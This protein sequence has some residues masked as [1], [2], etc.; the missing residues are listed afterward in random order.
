MITPYASESPSDSSQPIASSSRHTLAPAPIITSTP[1]LSRRL[2]RS[3]RRQLRKSALFFVVSSL[4]LPLFASANPLPPLLTVDSDFRHRSR[5]PSSPGLAN[6]HHIMSA[7]RQLA[8][9]FLARRSNGTDGPTLSIATY[10]PILQAYHMP[11]GYVV[12]N[13]QFNPGFIVLS[14]VI[15]FVGSLCTLELLIRRTTNS[16]WRNQ[17]LL[18]SAGFCFGAVSTFAMHFVFNN[19][20]SLHHPMMDQR[21]YP[22]LYLSYDP[23]FTILSLVVSCLAMTMAFFVMGTRLKDWLILPGQRRKDQMKRRGSPTKVEADDYGKWKKSH[24]KIVRRGTMGVGALFSQA[25]QAAKWSL[26]DGDQPRRTSLRDKLSGIGKDATWNEEAQ[27]IYSPRTETCDD[28]IGD[29]EALKE[30]DFRFGKDAVRME[31]ERRAGASTPTSTITS[32]PPSILHPPGSSG[33]LATPLPVIYASSSRRGSTVSNPVETPGDVFVPGFHFP[34]KA[35]PDYDAMPSLY[36]GGSGQL[37]TAFPMRDMS[38]TAGPEGLFAYQSDRRRASLPSNMLVTHRD[39]PSYS[40]PSSTL[41]RIQSLPEGD[42]EPATV[43][44]QHSK[45][46]SYD[47]K[48]APEVT[49]RSIIARL[50]SYS[51]RTDQQSERTKKVRLVSRTTRWTRIGMFL[52]L[53]VVTPVEVLKILI[54][55]TIAGCGVAGMH[56]IGQASITGLP[57]IAY[58]PSYVVG[59]IIIACGA[60]MIA[61]YIMFIMLRPKLKH[62]WFSKICVALILAVAVT[63]MHFCGM[64]G[65]VYA[66]PVGR[67]ISRHSKLTGT[68]VVITGIVAAL[69]FSACI[70]CAI[71]FLL[72]S[73][74]QRRERA[75]RRRV[76]VAAILLDDRDRVLVN[77]LDGT[78]PMCDIASL[79]GGDVPDS[80]RSFNQSVTSDSTVLGMDLS[81]GH[82]AFVSALKLSWTWKNPSLAHIQPVIPIDAKNS[83]KESVLAVSLADIRRGSMITNNTTSATENSRPPVSLTKFLERF[84]VSSTQLAVRLLGQA[85]GI[86]RLGVLYDQILTTGWVKLHNSND[87]VSKGQLIF[88]VRRVLSTAERA[89]LESRHFIFADPQS[90]ATTLHK[91]LSVPFEHTMPLLDDMRTFCDSTLQTRLQPGKLY[92][93]VAVV[94]ATPF[95]GL[96]ILLEKDMRSQLPM[97]EVCTLG[98]SSSS[99]SDDNALNGTVEE[100]GEAIAL[101]EGMTILSV[102]SRNMTANADQLLSKRVA[103]LLSALERAIVPMMDEMLT[104]E[105]MEHILPRLTLHPMLIPLTPGGTK[106]TV[107]SYIPPY[108]VIFYANYDAAVNTFTD[109]WLPFSLF[110]AQ[111]ACVMA[112]KI[113]AAAKMDQLYTAETSETPAS[114]YPPQRRPSKVQFDFPLP[115][116]PSRDQTPLGSPQPVD[117]TGPSTMFGGFTFPPKSAEE[118]DRDRSD[119]GHTHAHGNGHS[120]GGHSR[121][122]SSQPITGVQRVGSSRIAQTANNVNNPAG[123]TRRSSMARSRFGSVGGDSIAPS[124]ETGA[125]NNT[126]GYGYGYGNGSE[127]GHGYGLGP[128]SVAGSAREMVPLKPASV[129]VAAWEQD[130]LL[131]LLKTKLRADA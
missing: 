39:R 82:D 21:S 67:G 54:T 34:N 45:R 108:A 85:E 90:V 42:L 31:L 66:W 99:S 16:G 28:I 86:S 65:T 73:L 24:K 72:H 37:S 7:A 107:S 64:M 127:H 12:L 48:N 83:I 113:T 8:S 18:T 109:K 105:D 131:R 51:S 3:L 114:G 92:A 79:T 87:T 116:I 97:R 68:N 10:D 6:V 36:Q 44:S 9:D 106:R 23:G 70:A 103:N 81:T 49:P 102:I 38:S 2:P 27:G 25:S 124:A 117:E 43:S 122:S 32:K 94:Q 119:S 121:Q 14:Y 63:C 104:A 123:G 57:Y 78:L 98:L 58:T 1:L 74:N 76:V 129:G 19:A 89:D 101:L 50:S 15:A 30:L 80:R 77:S 95:D 69:A 55:G 118:E 56:Y 110:R 46:S 29:D 22:A 62:T 84:T 112:P 41:A 4:C 40:G 47:G 20:L 59:S 128:S 75:R 125:G 71:F 130:W 11:D 5:S 35:E 96:R 93:G 17:L 91:T 33:H 13:Q 52:G 61:L 120:H 53:D 115:Q 126:Y 88:L 26:M 60:V 111:N 100:I